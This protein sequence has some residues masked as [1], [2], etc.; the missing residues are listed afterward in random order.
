M[1]AESLT[2]SVGLFTMALL[3]PSWEKPLNFSSISSF[4]LL[5]SDLKSTL[6]EN[7]ISCQ[8]FLS[9]E[10]CC[11]FSFCFWFFGQVGRFLHVSRI[12]LEERKQKRKK[13]ATGEGVNIG[14]FFFPNKAVVKMSVLDQREEA[15]GMPGVMSRDLPVLW[16]IWVTFS[17]KYLAILRKLTR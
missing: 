3:S 8:K 1:K 14:F 11:F 17:F 10:N 2:R 6:Q 15:L 13:S 16:E 7:G 9:Q 4:C 5:S 12:L